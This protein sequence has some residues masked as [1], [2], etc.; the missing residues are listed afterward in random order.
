MVYM[1]NRREMKLVIR[2]SR[3]TY[4]AFRKY[5]AEYG[6]YEDA[7]RSLLEKAGAIKKFELR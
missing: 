5:S 3:E 7:L 2:C 4:V 6:C 1:V